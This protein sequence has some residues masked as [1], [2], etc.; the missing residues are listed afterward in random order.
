[1]FASFMFDIFL[2]FV[3]FNYYDNLPKKEKIIK[4]GF[5]SLQGTGLRKHKKR[6]MKVSTNKG[7][8]VEPIDRFIQFGNHLLHYPKLLEGEF[9]LRYKSGA[10]HTKFPNFNIS[11]DYKQFIIDT[12]TN[13]K[14]NHNLFKFLPNIEQ[15]HFKNLLRESG[16][17]HLHKVKTTIE[18][19]EKND[20][21]RFNILQGEINAGNN[22]RKMIDEFKNLLLKF[23]QTGKLTKKQ[24]SSAIKS[25]DN[26]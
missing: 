14:I 4:T 15:T 11:K 6:N 9:N 19:E 8:K 26:I 3:S 17:S 25:L 21:N 2:M 5:E 1:M 22:N 18:D 12:L 24:V 7:I 20:H 13:Q 10:N 23:S 16:L